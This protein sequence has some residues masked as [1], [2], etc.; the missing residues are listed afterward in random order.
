MN[1]KHYNRSKELR[2]KKK[3]KTTIIISHIRTSK[4]QRQNL[5]GSQKKGNFTYRETKIR[6][7]ADFSQ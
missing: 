1:D 4:N 3:R 2:R 5:E 6:V 7:A